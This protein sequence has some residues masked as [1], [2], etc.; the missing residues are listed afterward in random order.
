MVRALLDGRKTQTRRDL[1][2]LF[3][4]YS[5][6]LT[7]YRTSGTLKQIDGKNVPH[8]EFIHAEKG[9]FDSSTRP[10]GR[11]GWYV[12]LQYARGDRL[13]VRENLKADSNDQGAYWVTYAADGALPSVGHVRWGWKRNVHP[14]IFM[15]RWAS[16]L[17]LELTDVR[18]ERLQDISEADAMA[19]GAPSG[20]RHALQ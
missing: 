19:E 20:P 7:G 12:P 13:W 10:D 14:S 18:V 16:R 3:N 17:T 6:F 1:T 15:P 11:S 2:G 5:S 4:R 9:L 8:V